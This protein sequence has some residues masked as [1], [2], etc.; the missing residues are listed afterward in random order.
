M[1]GFFILFIIIIGEWISEQL[2]E[3]VFLLP[4]WV[5]EADLKSLYRRYL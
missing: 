4:L 2:R 3:Y 1:A 5:P